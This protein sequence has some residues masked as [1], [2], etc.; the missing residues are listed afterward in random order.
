MMLK[1]TGIIALAG[2]LILVTASLGAQDQPDGGDLP[3]DQPEK[4]E[5]KEEAPEETADKPAQTEG[6]E[7]AVTKKQKPAGKKSEPAPEEKVKRPEPERTVPRERPE[8]R[9]PVREE[10]TG[11]DGATG[12]LLIEDENFLHRRIPGITIKDEPVSD[13]GD[14][15]KIPDDSLGED[16]EDEDESGFLGL[17]NETAS[18][19]GKIGLVV[20]FF[21]IFV[22][23]RSRT[24]K[25][26]RKKVVRT[27]PK[28]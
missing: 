26:S 14:I 18:T 22:I 2:A 17:S 28:K 7:E 5:K 27:I 1:R 23:Y 16:G 6:K 9:E 12:L 21:L 13:A 4:V 3:P 10:D 11:A 25:V 8:K 15:V 20:L 19:I 24:R